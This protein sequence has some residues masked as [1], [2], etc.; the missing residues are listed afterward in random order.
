MKPAHDLGMHVGIVTNRLAVG[1]DA[2]AGASAVQRREEAREA[3]AEGGVALTVSLLDELIEAV[4]AQLGLLTRLRDA[5]TASGHEQVTLQTATGPLQYT[6]PLSVNDTYS[7]TEVSEILSPTGKGHRTIAQNRRR[8]N[9]LLG[10]KIGSRYR[11]PKFQIDPARHE[12]RRV[13]AHANRLLECD[14]DPWGSLDWWFSADEGLDGR[15]PIDLLENHEL[16][17][18]VVDFAIERSRQGMD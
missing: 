14:A 3:V 11:Y 8:T 17:D 15:R 13:V 18:E 9:E 6:L 2:T 12:I 4:R 10:V 7:S 1:E 16:S 5:Q